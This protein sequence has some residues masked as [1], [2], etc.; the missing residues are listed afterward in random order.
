MPPVPT[1]TSLSPAKGFV[2]TS[3][4]ISLTGANFINNGTR[5]S[6]DGGGVTVKSVSVSNPT[7]LVAALNIDSTAA[8]GDRNVTVSTAGGVSAAKTFTVQVSPIQTILSSSS[9]PSIFGE[10][11]RFTATVSTTSGGIPSGTI[12]F[13]DG[14][15]TIGTVELSNGQANFSNSALSVGPHSITAVY[16][17]DSSFEGS[18][19]PV[20]S[21]TVNKNGVTTLLTSSVNPAAF[22]Q[23]LTLALTVTAGSGIPDGVVTF[24]DGSTA[25]GTVTLVS[26][27]AEFSTAALTVG[28][29][30]ITAVY[31][32][33]PDF[34]GAT[35]DPLMQAVNKSKTTTTTTVNSSA[36]PSDYGQAI[37]FTATVGTGADGSGTP[38]GVVTFKDGATV[39]GSR[40]LTS[41]QATFSTQELAATTHTISAV[42]GGDDNFETS[43]STALTQTV[44]KTG[45]TTTLT[46]S[47][48]PSTFGQSVTFT[49]A[50]V[51]GD[52]AATGTVIFMD[53][54]SSLGSANLADGRA[55]FRT[56]TLVRG[57]HSIK[58]IYGGD[59]N[60]GGSTSALLTQ[61]V[62]KAHDDD[63]DDDDDDGHR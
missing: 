24:K 60:F 30:S 3:F 61:T 39:L 52:I 20:L 5:L 9:N 45:T 58:A 29:H 36:N 17:G 57:V 11:V 42:Y 27:R 43:S 49:A 38:S 7:T 22:G 18:T 21:Q 16:S 2:G 1:L 47:A 31:G 41:G 62:N 59:L 46:S 12:Q 56:A 48:N 19:S 55:I 35:S 54:P 15:T 40:T 6:I 32:G 4:S 33:S 8:T 50:V 13:K 51:T 63:D 10:T 53:G 44:N 34:M 26:G 25:L 14:T 37:T 23:S 28:A